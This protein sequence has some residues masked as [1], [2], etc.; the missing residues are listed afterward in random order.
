MI[1]QG[2]CIG[3]WK[4]KGRKLMLATCGRC[5]VKENFMAGFAKRL[6]RRVDLLTQFLLSYFVAR[7]TIRLCRGNLKLETS[8]DACPTF[9]SPVFEVLFFSST[10]A[11]KSH[12][13]NMWGSLSPCCKVSP[14]FSMLYSYTT[15]S[16]S[17]IPVVLCCFASV[18]WSASS[19]QLTAGCAFCAPCFSAYRGNLGTFT[20][21]K[22]PA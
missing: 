22:V 16:W 18:S 8:R 9:W 13:R 19:M 5:F 3:V 7:E 15:I 21:T 4:C 10:C 2:G 14:C 20:P 6:R 11:R 1:R 17:A 12:R